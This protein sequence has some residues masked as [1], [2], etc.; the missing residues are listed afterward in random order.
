[1]PAVRRTKLMELMWK[2]H[3]WIYRRTGGRLLGA[4]MG[5]PILLLTTRGRKTG[6]LRTRALMYLPK[7]DACIVVASYAGEPRHPA[8]WL[9]L[10]A[11]PHATV[12]CGSR[13]RPMVAREAEGEE[14][15]ALWAEVVKRE[16]GY[17]T[18]AERT[19]RRIPV[20]VL[21]PEA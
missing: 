12:Q 15:A 8:W 5:M 17:A 6:E 9:N 19:T 11:D 14:R 4:M 1:V 13:I 3:P 10:Q 20:V 7:G 21:E 16:S 2:I 18:Y